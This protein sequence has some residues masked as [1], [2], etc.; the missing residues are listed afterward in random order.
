MRL[1]LDSAGDPIMSGIEAL[2]DKVK[3]GRASGA[4]ESDFDGIIEYTIE[5]VA[6]GR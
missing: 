1:V 4:P 2:R 3:D 5:D 6:R